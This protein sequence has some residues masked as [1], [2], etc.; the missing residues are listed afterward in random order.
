MYYFIVNK[1]SR[2][3]SATRIWSRLNNLLKAGKVDF[4]VYN[5]MYKNHATEIAARISRLEDK[6]KRIVVVGGDGTVNEVVNGITDFEHTS[7]SVIPTGSGNDFA[8]GLGLPGDPVE[9]LR[10]ILRCK[11][12]EYMDLGQVTCPEE[13]MT[14]LYAISAGIG[15]DAL[16]C[17][18]TDAS[19]AK[20]VLNALH[21]G[22]LIYLVL[23]VQSLFTMKD[24]KAKVTYDNGK[25]YRRYDK[26]IF[27]AAMNFKAEGGGVPMAPGASAFDKELSVC[28]ASGV[29][30]L[31][32]FFLLPFLVAAKHEKLKPFDVMNAGRIEIKAANPVELHTD[33]EYLGDFKKVIFECLPGKL[34]IRR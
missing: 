17:K 24:E 10:N 9:G 29:T 12:E 23:T 5:T 1:Q 16:V 19:G 18:K 30:R 28:A 8:R 4:K 21:L 11:T 33:G 3:G 14:R 15:M 6:D 7:F 26:L 31:Q 25:K 27:L 20:K 2:S 22:K 34:K 13:G 32:G